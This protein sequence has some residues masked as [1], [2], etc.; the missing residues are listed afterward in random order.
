[1][2]RIQGIASELRISEDGAQSETQDIR[3]EHALQE[4]HRQ[5]RLCDL[6]GLAGADGDDAGGESSGSQ[7][8]DQ[9]DQQE[10]ADQEERN[11][12]VTRAGLGPRKLV[13]QLDE[14]GDERSVQVI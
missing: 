3:C 11:P 10:I 12:A 7:Q 6:F 13:A 4:Q 5:N 14:F 2:K 8:C 1:V 9:K